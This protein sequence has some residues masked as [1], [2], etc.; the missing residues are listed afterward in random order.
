[1]NKQIQSNHA[2]ESSTVDS[3]IIAVYKGH[4]TRGN[5]LHAIC[6]LLQNRTVYIE[7]LLVVWNIKEAAWLIINNY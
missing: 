2:H 4:H 7:M 6:C 3:I 5:L 1:M